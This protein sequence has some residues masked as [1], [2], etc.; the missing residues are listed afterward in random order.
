MFT[1]INATIPV[2]LAFAIYGLVKGWDVRLVL[3]AAALALASLALK[4]WIVLDAFLST[5]GDGKIV[6]PICSAV[7]YAFVLKLIGADQEM[8]RLL[9]APLRRRRWLLIPGGCAVGFVT[10]MA[11]T[12]QMAAAATVGLVLIPLLLAAGYHP[13]IAAATLVL[14]CSAGGNL[15]NPGDPDIVAIV[16]NTA[17][18]GGT[19]DAVLHAMIVP[20]LLGF[21]AAT[22]AFWLLSRWFPPDGSGKPTEEAASD[23]RRIDLSKAL[24]PLLPVVMLFVTLPGLGL[25]PW[26]L[27]YYADGLPVPHAMVISTIVAML[28]SRANA[29]AQ[30][31]AFFEG[32]GFGYVH[33]ISVIIVATCFIEAMKAVGLVQELVSLI[34]SSGPLGKLAAGFFP[35]LLAVVSGSGVAPSVAFSNAV[36]PEVSAGNLAGA[37]DLGVIGSIGATFGRTMSPVAAVVIF[38]ATLTNVPPLQIVRRTAPA[39]AVGALVVLAIVL[40]R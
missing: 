6:G 10:N 30:T 24:L 27:K 26:L 14:G 22:V 29:P 35:W 20:E 34:Q 15:F 40:A 18:N 38:A 13:F 7:G 25:L 1:F 2:I 9:I 11:I 19:A 5:M 23:D 33:V 3:F 21:I 32:M 37:I 28:V 36:L 8:V 39:L 17:V 31:K 4:P 16:N 12:S